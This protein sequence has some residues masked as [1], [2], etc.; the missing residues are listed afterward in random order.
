MIK[1]QPLPIQV[2]PHR[3]RST[4]ESSWLRPYRS[5]LKAH[6]WFV[7]VVSWI[8]STDNQSSEGRKCQS[9]K[10]R[11]K[12]MSM[13]ALFVFSM[14]AFQILFFSARLST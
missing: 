4:D 3:T 10:T 11:M 12:I 13:T 9:K 8:H 2:H 5:G 1:L 14:A 6:D 7:Y